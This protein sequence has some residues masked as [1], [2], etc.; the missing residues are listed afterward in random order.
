MRDIDVN[1]RNLRWAFDAQYVETESCPIIKA[2]LDKY[3]I[4]FDDV[5]VYKFKTKGHIYIVRF[6]HFNSPRNDYHIPTE[7]PKDPFQTK[8]PRLLEAT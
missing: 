2:E 5:Y 1:W 8:L 6:P 4:F 3:G 7:R